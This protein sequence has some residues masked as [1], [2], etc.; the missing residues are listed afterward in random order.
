V[1]GQFCGQC[2][3]AAGTFNYLTN[4]YFVEVILNRSGAEAPVPQAC[5]LRIF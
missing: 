1:D 3:F 2:Q 4:L 5:T